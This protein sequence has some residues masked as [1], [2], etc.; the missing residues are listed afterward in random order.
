MV[1]KTVEV[2]QVRLIDRTVDGDCL[3]QSSSLQ[4]KSFQIERS[5]ETRCVTVC[6]SEGISDVD[7]LHEKT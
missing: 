7:T 5:S 1:Q 4:N 3:H 6:S 2:P